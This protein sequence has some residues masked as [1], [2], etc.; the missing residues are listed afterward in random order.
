MILCIDCKHYKSGE[1][2]LDDRC[3]HDSAAYGGVR[4]VLRHGCISMRAGICFE[5]KLFEPA[6]APVMGQAKG[7]GK[8]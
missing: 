1:T 4:E 3:L 6:A 5:G 7:E 2:E 8:P